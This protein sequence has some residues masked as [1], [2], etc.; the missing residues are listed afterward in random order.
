MLDYS[1]FKQL[2]IETMGEIFAIQKLINEPS[3]TFS[4]LSFF[5]LAMPLSGKEEEAQRFNSPRLVGMSRVQQPTSKALKGFSLVSY[6][7]KPHTGILVPDFR[8]SEGNLQ[9]TLISADG[10][11]LLHSLNSLEMI[12]TRDESWFSN[13]WKSSKVWEINDVTVS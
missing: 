2:D 5:L 12:T 4:F 8:N 6:L 7:R 1:L 13:F 11:Y 9:V 10:S 3:V